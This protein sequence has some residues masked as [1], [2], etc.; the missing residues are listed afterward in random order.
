MKSELNSPTDHEADN[1]VKKM[2]RGRTFIKP[3][4]GFRYSTRGFLLTLFPLVL[5]GLKKWVGI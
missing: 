2:R 3:L 1:L 5:M 4:F